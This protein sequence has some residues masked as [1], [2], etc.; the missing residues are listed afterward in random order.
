[1]SKLPSTP[2]MC[3]V[4]FDKQGL[5]EFESAETK[6]LTLSQT[7]EDDKRYGIMHP[8]NGKYFTY[9]VLNEDTE[10]TQKQ[11]LRSA[12]YAQKRW[13]IYA[14]L[15]KFKRVKKDYNGIIDFRIEFRTVDSD[16]DKKLTNNTI[17]Y[18]YY[19][20]NKIDHPL[21][22]LCVVNKAFFFT[23]HGNGVYGTE[24]QK[25]GIQVQFPHQKYSTLDFDKVY[26]HELGH[27]LGLPHD[28]E[29]E[30]MMAFREDLMTEFPSSR[31]QSRII[32]KYG[33]RIMSA[34]W[35]MRWLRWLKWASDR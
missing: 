8:A 3:R 30:N 33:A 7:V 22:G 19:P 12:S 31:D 1:M 18:H 6:G 21:R 24:F 35:R 23:S 2:L 13:R 25:Y 27:G 14:K 16:P 28:S 5:V 17:M 26:A 29:P 20:I 10:F 32:I 4:L 11:A 9:A 15:P 34:W